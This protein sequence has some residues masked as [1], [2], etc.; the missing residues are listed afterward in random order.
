MPYA[1]GTGWQA[2][3]LPYDG[4]ELSFVA[5]VPDDI[6]AFGQGLSGDELTQIATSL[7]QA[8]VALEM[9]KFTIKG[10]SF[11]LKTALT[12]LGMTD[13]FDPGAAD[14][15]GMTQSEKLHISDV[16]H[17]AFVSVD[18]A[19]TEAAAATAVIAI[20]NAGSSNVVQ[21][22]LDH[23]FLFFIRDN[24]TGAIVFLGRVVRAG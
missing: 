23:P 4:N 15:S 13:A 19:G 5:V 11:S 24:V 10:A 17:Q 1:K 8:D 16:I 21:L 9:P 3:A 2:V 14:F 6:N 22:T 18:E 12:S 20:G 7:S